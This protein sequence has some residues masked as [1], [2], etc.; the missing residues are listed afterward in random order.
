MK[1]KLQ[2]VTALGISCLTNAFSTST[3]TQKINQLE[4]KLNHL[5]KQMHRH[6]SAP[7][8]VQKTRDYFASSLFSPNFTK[9]MTGSA[10][11]GFSK[12][13]GSDASFNILDFNPMFLISYKNLIFLHSALDFTLDSQGN[14]QTSL[15]TLNASF[16]VN[17]HLALGI[18]KFDSPLGYFVNNLSPSWINR[19][20]DT[21]VGFD[22]NQAAP[23]A[24]IGL[25]ATGAFS[26]FSAGD[27]TYNLTVANAPQAMANTTSNTV[28][29][30]NTDGTLGNYANY[31][32]GG[33]IGFRPIPAFELGVS[34]ALGTVPLLD[35]ANA[36][37]VLQKHR[38]YS[39]LGADANFKENA[40]S[41]RG[42]Y[43][44]QHI[45]A[46]S[47]SA[48][49]SAAATWHAWY[50][51]SAYWIPNTKWEPVLRYGQYHTPSTSNNQKQF[52][53][54]IDY[55][56]APSIVAQGEYARLIQQNQNANQYTLQLAI[57]Y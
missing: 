32:Y 29:H 48:N 11:L 42:E 1:K 44:Q 50:L 34:V 8:P 21:P 25:A 46:D 47:G 12:T 20:P 30:I 27:I 9:M 35:N 57:G 54:G 49:A 55:W 6:A 13:S 41:L 15:D 51:Q 5:E 10:S 33:R 4:R 22:S 40:W 53:A 26:I 14:T 28:D 19:L 56:I 38:F 24:A 39:V 18:G 43:I 23:Q 3:N 7:V 37:T 16:F 31:L 45:S 2:I 36:S 52:A 17:N